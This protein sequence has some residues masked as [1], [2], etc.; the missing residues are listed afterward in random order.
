MRQPSLLQSRF[1]RLIICGVLA[2]ILIWI[3]GLHPAQLSLLTAADERTEQIETALKNSE[4]KQLLS[5]AQSKYA[6][7]SS[8]L[9]R[10]QGVIPEASETGSFV[11]ALEDLA[12]RSGLQ[13]TGLSTK[14]QPKAVPRAATTTSS[15]TSTKTE[16]PAAS[17][18]TVEQELLQSFYGTTVDVR[19][20]GNY[21]SLR[22]FV[23]LIRQ[24]ERFVS[25]TSI[26]MST[27]KQAAGTES[28][29]LTGSISMSIF[30]RQAAKDAEAN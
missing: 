3:F 20:S 17:N 24:M 1:V 15:K 14:L 29:T 4:K 12:A 19:F 16:T 18:K 11:S 26:N 27:N 9:G 10:L 25:I 23:Q 30:H 28:S 22:S 5:A 8:D 2:L 13:I 7:L 6:S 21:A